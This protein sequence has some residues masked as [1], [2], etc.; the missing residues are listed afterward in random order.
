MPLEEQEKKALKIVVWIGA[1]CL[2]AGIVFGAIIGA[3]IVVAV[4]L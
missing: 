4:K 1:I 3:L 2:A